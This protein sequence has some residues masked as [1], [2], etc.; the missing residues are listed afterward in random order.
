MKS[1]EVQK[2]TG[3]TRKAIEYYVAFLD[4][5]PDLQ[6]NQE[7]QE[8]LEEIS[9]EISP[10][11]LNEINAGKTFAIENTEK[12]LEENAST[13]NAYQQMKNSEDLKSLPIRSIQK[14]LKALM[15]ESGYYEIAIPL[16][17]QMSPAYDEYYNKLMRANKHYQQWMKNHN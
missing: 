3:L 7:E 4:Q 2:E 1:N 16:L 5:M 10:E 13:I 6:L 12:W 8:F 17:R 15:E 9:S 14:K 11:M